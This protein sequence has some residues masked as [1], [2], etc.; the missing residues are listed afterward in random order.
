[1]WLNAAGFA[2]AGA[3][4]KVPP[5]GADGPGPRWREHRPPPPMGQRPKV[6]PD[7]DL[8][9]CCHTLDGLTLDVTQAGRTTHEGWRHE[10]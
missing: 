1:M 4:A 3:G 8:R 6:G 9:L 2:R 7:R 10:R 5:V